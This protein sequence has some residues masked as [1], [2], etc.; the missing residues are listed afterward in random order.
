[1]KFQQ[2]R[3]ATVKITYGGQTFLVDPWLSPQHMTGCFALM[4]VICAMNGRGDPRK[5]PVIDHCRT[6]RATTPEQKFIM[7]PRCPLPMTVKAINSGVSAYLCTHV[8]LD[9][10]GLS[11][12]G[13][14][15]ERLDKY[16]PIY[17]QSREDADFLEYSGMRDVRVVWDRVS[18]G[19]TELIKVKAVHGTVRPCGDAS[20]FIFR[21]PNEKTL[22]LCG[23]TVWC[24]EVRQTL[25]KYHPDV[26]ITNNCAAE[27]KGY[28]RLI[29]DDNDLYQLYKAAPG[30]T[31]IASHMDNVPHATLTRETLKA[32]LRE[33]GILDKILIPDDGESYSL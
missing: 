11:P 17:A 28:G 26:I 22:Y 13:K 32:K 4:P 27:L 5:K 2:I 12:T 14:G 1:M 30:A 25:E 16:I 29:M 31:I 18:F 23:D 20:G 10:I 24:D 9:H 21:S 33:K 19:D 8:H 7:V 15:C 6:W 3:S